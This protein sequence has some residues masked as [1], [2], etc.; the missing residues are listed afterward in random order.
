M[1][2]KRRAGFLFFSFCAFASLNALAAPASDQRALLTATQ[3]AASRGDREGFR[4]ALARLKS[5]GS[6]N[7]VVSVYDDLDRVWTFEFETPTGA[8]FNATSGLVKVM[9]AYPGW[10][11]AV[12]N[13]TVVI[14][15][16][17]FYPSRETR[18]FLMREA[19]VRL[20]RIGLGRVTEIATSKQ[21]VAKTS[22]PAED[23]TK[24][25]PPVT[26]K[27]HPKKKKADNNIEPVKASTIVATAVPKAEPAASPPM[28]S[29]TTSVL[30]TTTSNSSVP[31]S[32]ATQT[33]Q[34]AAPTTSPTTSSAADTIASD[35][36]T[37]SAAPSSDSTASDTQR[38]ST[39]RNVILPIV[40]I[41]AGVGVLIVLFRT[42]S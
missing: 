36:T 40:L 5:S 4:D 12:A 10:E 30:T 24:A 26:V 27:S 37:S 20:S 3:A 15:G 6:S 2:H 7:D 38:P 11:N 28:T 21:P 34:S 19:A 13:Q 39:G 1:L 25:L 42:S 41:I 14:G 22:A 18:D 8:F 31:P 16:A 17:K 32:P 33:T 29:S 23:T 9:S 35:V